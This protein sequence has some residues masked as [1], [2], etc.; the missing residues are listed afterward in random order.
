MDLDGGENGSTTRDQLDHGDEDGVG[1]RLALETSILDRFV[2]TQASRGVIADPR[3]LQ[4][5]YLCLTSRVLERPVSLA[6]KGPSSAGKSYA[7]E[8]TLPFFPP[9]AYH[10]LSSMSERAL[11]YDTEPL[12]HRILIL[13]EAAGLGG[14]LASYLIRSLLSEG[15]V[16][17]TTV[18]QTR[19]GLIPRT[20]EREGPTGLLTTTTAV[21]LHPENE[22]RLL[23]VPM[24][25]S[26][27]QTKRIMQALALGGGAEVDLAP[28]LALQ[29]WL[30]RAEHRVVIPYAQALAELIPPVATRLRRDFGLLLTLIQTHAIL[31]QRQRDWDTEGR[32][33][34]TLDDYAAIRA[35]VED[36][37]AEAMGA[38]VPTTIR[39][40]VKAVVDLHA[41]ATFFGTPVDLSITGV[42]KVLGVDK[43]TASRRVRQAIERGY[44]RNLEGVKGRPG[45]LEPAAPL[46]E[47]QPVLPTVEVV[48]E[49][50]GVAPYIKG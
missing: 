19:N 18:E 14:E 41:E 33:I 37:L 35:L 10:A 46:P 43:S 3:V 25:E 27:Q 50:C 32:V 48:A 34:A 23:S 39:Q 49:R 26:P 47:D 13:Y 22:T 30:E 44:L 1:H 40:T 11:P 42:A 28:W 15:R 24:G 20:I 36:L 9:T 29:A 5:V 16:R 7:V 4:L 12:Q 31:H 6:I 8:Q 17:Y 21:S 45:K 38:T 2:E